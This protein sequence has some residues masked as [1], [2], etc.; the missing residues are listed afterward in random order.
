MREENPRLCNDLRITLCDALMLVFFSNLCCI[1]TK[2][3]RGFSWT[4][5]FIACS[6]SSLTKFG[7]P[8][9]GAELIVLVVLK[10]TKVL[11]T[12]DLG[13]PRISLNITS[14]RYTNNLITSFFAQF[15]SFL[16]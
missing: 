8:D 11:W 14:S 4:I 7:H 10:R 13:I 12:V 3:L 5:F 15:F 16:I 6:F 2:V 9:R 1:S